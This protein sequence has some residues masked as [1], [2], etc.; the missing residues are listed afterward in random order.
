M[1]KVTDQEM[2]D[3]L[4][5][6]KSQED[7]C[8]FWNNVKNKVSICNKYKNEGSEDELEAYE[9]LFSFVEDN[10]KYIRLVRDLMISLNRT[11]CDI[12]NRRVFPGFKEK[13]IYLF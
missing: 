11:L 8:M 10:I 9:D 12:E 1:V 5:E 7:I 13:Y 2:K 6:G 4:N 3:I